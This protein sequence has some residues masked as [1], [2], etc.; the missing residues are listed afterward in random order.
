MTNTCG[1]CAKYCDGRCSLTRALRRPGDWCSFFDPQ[2]FRHHFRVLTPAECEAARQEL[3]NDPE[4][5]QEIREWLAD[6]KNDKRLE[7]K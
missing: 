4:K 1:R 7:G 2:V 5:M 3:M 6:T